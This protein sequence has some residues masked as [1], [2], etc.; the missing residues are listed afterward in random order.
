MQNN[1]KILIL[2]A[3]SFSSGFEVSSGLIQEQ[4][5][6]KLHNRSFIVPCLVP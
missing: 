2:Q 5:N 4:R 3:T 6:G 1:V